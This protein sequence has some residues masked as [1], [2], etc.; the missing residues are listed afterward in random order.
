VKAYGKN[1]CLV[2]D[3]ICDVED[4]DSVPIDCTECECF[5]E[6]YEEDYEEEEENGEMDFTESA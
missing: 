5:F 3:P 1:W 4:W 2:D 6:C